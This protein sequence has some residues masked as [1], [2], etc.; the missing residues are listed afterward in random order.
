MCMNSKKVH[1]FGNFLWFPPNV[2]RFRNVQDLKKNRGFETK[3][4]ILTNVHKIGKFCGFG[5]QLWI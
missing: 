1:G 4:F 2:H 5:K 3:V